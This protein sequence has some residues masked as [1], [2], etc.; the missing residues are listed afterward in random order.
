MLLIFLPL[1]FNMCNKFPIRFDIILSTCVHFIKTPQPNHGRNSKC[2][3]VRGPFVQTLCIE[4]D[5]YMDAI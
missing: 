3:K 5:S 1:S 4:K 2:L